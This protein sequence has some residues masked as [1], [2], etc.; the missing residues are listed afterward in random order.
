VIGGPDFQAAFGFS[1]DA[2]LPATLDSLAGSLQLVRAEG[3]SDRVLSALSYGP[4]GVAAPALSQALVLDRGAWRPDSLPHAHG[5]AGDGEIAPFCR[6]RCPGQRVGLSLSTTQDE[7]PGVAKF[8]DTFSDV[9]YDLARAQFDVSSGF[10]H[11]ELLMTDRYSLTGAVQPETLETSVAVLEAHRDSCSRNACVRSSRRLQLIVNGELA[12]SLLASVSEHGRLHARVPFTPGQTT[13][14]Q[15]LATADGLI[16]PHLVG[17][18]TGR[19]EFAPTHAGEHVTSCWGYDS[20]RARLVHEAGW[21]LSPHL[22]SITWKMTADPGFTAD[23]ERLDESDPLGDWV[24]RETRPVE[25][26]GLLR[27]SDA[28]VSAGSTYRYRLAWS[29]EFGSYTSDEIRIPVDRLPSFG[30]LSANPNPSR[31]NLR[32]SFELPE[33]SAVR[34]ELFDLLGRRVREV[35]TSLAAGSQQV[36]LDQG[37]RLPPGLYQVRLGAGGREARLTLVVLP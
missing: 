33:P 24:P 1:A 28:K 19:L 9:S 2:T 18:V 30:L 7:S 25:P 26:S 11:A 34:L 10:R 16:T 13:R 5:F 8:S 27:F 36:A 6:V 3:G 31:G 17:R 15:V 14:I 21:S 4:G 37:R 20:E 12:D 29:D 35:R 22:V 32:V 23:V